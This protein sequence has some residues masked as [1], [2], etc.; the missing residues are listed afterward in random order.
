L[1]SVYAMRIFPFFLAL[2]LSGCANPKDGGQTVYLFRHAEKVTDTDTEDP[3]LSPAGEQRA[4][5]TAEILEDTEVDRFYSTRYIRNMATLSPAAIPRGMKIK[6]YEW[7][8]WE[9]MV[10]EITADAYN[11]RTVVICG[12]GDNLLPMIESFGCE[13]PLDSLGPYEHDKYFIVEMKD[14][15]CK[16]RTEVY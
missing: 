15:D 6:P 16:V 14:G 9:P 10:R 8:D 11:L 3:P 13:A 12:H 7:H 1:T 2:L 5:Q 4:A